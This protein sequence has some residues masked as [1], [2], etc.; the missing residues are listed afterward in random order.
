MGPIGKCEEVHQWLCTRPLWAR[1]CGALAF[2]TAGNDAD[3]SQSFYRFPLFSHLSYSF[4][5]FSSFKLFSYF[6]VFASFLTLKLFQ[7]LHYF[8]LFFII[9]PFQ[10]LSN[11][12]HP[13]TLSIFYHFSHS[14]NVYSSFSPIQTVLNFPTLSIYSHFL[15]LSNFF[16]LFQ[17]FL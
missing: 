2:G 7:I 5:L 14:F 1:L 11:F 6:L 16:H 17:S 4:N 12:F 3:H 13:P 15:T 8:S 10:T 9:L